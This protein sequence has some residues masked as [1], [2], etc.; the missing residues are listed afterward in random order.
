MGH[1]EVGLLL[2]GAGTKSSC[3]KYGL[4]LVRLP[5]HTCT[6][7]DV[8]VSARKP[9]PLEWE[10]ARETVI[11]A[12]QHNRPS[13][14]FELVPVSEAY[15]RV[16]TADLTA[17]RDYPAL[18][19]S[20]RDGFAIHASESPGT[21]H[22]AG[23]SRA[24]EMQSSSLPSGWALEIMTGAP[25][26]PGADAIV[27]VENVERI[28]GNV[29]VPQQA[30][31]GQFINTKGAEAQQ[32][33]VLIGSGT[34]LDASHIGTLAMTGH[35]QI[36]V[37][38][39]P[40][41]AILSTGDEL[42]D[43]AASP[44]PHQIR[45]SNSYSLAALVNAAGG[46]PVIL[47]VA[48]DTED[49]LLRLLEQGLDHDLLLISGGVSA[50]KYDLVKPCL[51]RLG[52]EFLFE[53]VRIQPGQP[54]AFGHANGKFFFGLPGNPG[55]SIVTFQL[56]ARAA[57]EMLSGVSSPHLEI[58]HAVFETPFRHKTG[59]T[60]FLPATLRED[61]LLKHVP[62]QGSSDIPAL[63]KANV[64]LIADPERESWNAGD[65]IRV[66]LKL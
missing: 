20:L 61:G 40:S 4:F 52:A 27:M 30:V 5:A 36:E 47:P 37:F 23:E 49:G 21:F 3:R 10:Q 15:R 65:S 66:M 44:A 64:F 24:G 12:V 13:P 43:V 17:D 46:D 14:I 58:F 9:A 59:L 1:P 38:R 7:P 35:P 8:D 25:V 57:L 48:P 33:N 55:S 22:I 56:F 53:R 54:T 26:P 18:A 29:T 16:L 51:R 6:I 62:W 32:G 31:S 41:V 39:K 19:R 28:N 42:V 63:A 50:G 60:R 34:R 45:N 11:Q 2:R